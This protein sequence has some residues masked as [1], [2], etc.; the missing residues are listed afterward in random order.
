MKTSPLVSHD[1]FVTRALVS[2]FLLLAAG[3]AQ[4]QV[5]FVDVYHT[6]IIN[7]VVVGGSSTQF[8]SGLT[9]PTGVVFDAAGNLVVAN[10]GNS[11]NAGA[12]LKFTSG[13]GSSTFATGLNYP[14]GLA[15]DSSGNLYVSSNLGNIRKVD[16]GG[17]VSI[18]VA[19]SDGTYGMAFDTAGNLYVADKTTSSINRIA[20]GTSTMVTFISSV[21]DP[22]G[23]VFDNA[24]NLYVALGSSGKIAKYNPD[25]SINNLN[26]VTGV[27]TP[28]F[29]AYDGT[30]FFVS[31]EGAL[32]QISAAGSVST[33]MTF[34]L[35]TA[36][37]PWGVAVAVPEASTGAMLAG[38]AALGVAALRRWRRSLNELEVER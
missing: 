13:G 11:S 31:A 21:T 16:T 22:N 5:V 36:G 2:S 35:S 32:L 20:A 14:T 34:G 7:K 8:A 12:I 18:F 24:G 19:T 37:G 6:G 30:S 1:R 33:L 10:S 15:I 17:N 27:N 25:G 26:F 4:A 29:M 28:N 23:L 9:Y 3:L 38:L